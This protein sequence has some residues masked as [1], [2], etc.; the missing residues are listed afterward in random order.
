MPYAFKPPSEETFLAKHPVMD[1][2][3]Y[4]ELASV[5]LY[6]TVRLIA[7]GLV[8]KRQSYR[9]GWVIHESRW[10]NG[11]ADMRLVP[12]A[13]LDWM[14]PYVREAYPDFETATGMTADEMQELITEQAQKRAKHTDK[15]KR[16]IKN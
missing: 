5:P 10:A 8:G 12:K 9:F 3:L 4:A 11:G 16:I 13:I 2:R 15:P 7:P 1:A 6:V 14:A